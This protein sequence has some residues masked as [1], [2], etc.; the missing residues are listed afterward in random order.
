MTCG[1]K[2]CKRTCWWG[3]LVLVMASLRRHESLNHLCQL[4]RSF[5]WSTRKLWFTGVVVCDNFARGIPIGMNVL[6][7]FWG[8]LLTLNQPDFQRV[9]PRKKSELCYRTQWDVAAM[10][11]P[12]NTMVDWHVWLGQNVFMSHLYQDFKYFNLADERKIGLRYCS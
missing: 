9:P 12:F 4:K 11:K 1:K 2:R 3:H 5:R 7:V 6:A 8:L 10:A